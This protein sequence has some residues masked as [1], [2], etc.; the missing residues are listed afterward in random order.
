MNEPTQSGGTTS[1]NIGSATNTTS[2]PT[3]VSPSA[4]LSESGVRASTSFRREGRSIR[5][6]G[7]REYRC[8]TR[9]ECTN[10]HPCQKSGLGKDRPT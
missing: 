8:V 6:R 4:S 7:G 2:E 10:R 5:C 9:L 1:A 3:A